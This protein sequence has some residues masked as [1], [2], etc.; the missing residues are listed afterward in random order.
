MQIDSI[1]LTNFAG[2]K[3]L[4]IDFNYK[5]DDTTVIIG[6]NGSGKTSIIE[7][8]VTSLSWL[9]ARILREEGKGSPIDEL[10]IHNGESTATTAISVG[11]N[12]TQFKWQ[13]AKTRKG[14]KAQSST[15]LAN[16]TELAKNL[17]ASLSETPDTANLPL[18]A[19]Y[20]TERV[21]VEVP[22]KI[23]TKH[24]FGQVDGYDQALSAGVD[25]RRFFEWF[26]ERE[27]AENENTLSLEAL[28]SLKELLD[29]P[30]PEWEKF[31]ANIKNR[32]D[33]QLNAVRE[34]ISLFMES[35]TNLRIKRS[36]LRMLVDKEGQELDVRQLSQGE[37]SLMALVGDISR[38]LAMMNPSLEN[39]LHGNGIILIDEV[40]MHLH[41]RWQRKIV[42]NL[43][44]AFPKCQFILT[45]H[46]PLVI[47]D[48]KNVNT[49]MLDNGEMRHVENL[50][51][52]DANLVLSREMG[53]PVR[54]AEVDHAID[55]IYEL[56]QDNELD[57]AEERLKDLRLDL[58]TNHLEVAKLEL[59]LKRKSKINEANQ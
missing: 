49:L 8:V 38:R 11:Y 45:T 10:K 30:E 44:R 36:P 26:R 13:I 25:F 59:I 51:G 14:R 50:Y 43:R 37:K 4:E 21:V 55:T 3:S 54:N 40:D 39:P 47:S 2:F 42:T 31:E 19:Y 53:V 58:P 12:S 1:E 35:F 33:R 56:I 57:L 9:T 18:I 6:N 17:R 20:S 23:R 46:S 41:P 7:G 28:N 24:T 27:D 29:M 22:L 32:K 15:E 5:H 34:A 48:P 52:L 16:A